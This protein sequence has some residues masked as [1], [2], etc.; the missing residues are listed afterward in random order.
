VIAI[1]AAALALVGA[2]SRRISSAEHSRR[3]S[4]RSSRG[5]RNLFKRIGGGE[6]S[7]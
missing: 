3:S 4:C 5:C 1:N 7:G 6:R 2:A